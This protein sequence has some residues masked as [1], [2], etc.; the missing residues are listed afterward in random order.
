MG[1]N[2]GEK[3][4]ISLNDWL[5]GMVIFGMVVS[6]MVIFGL[7]KSPWV[8]SREEDAGK[9]RR[10]RQRGGGVAARRLGRGRRR[11]RGGAGPETRDP[12][13]KGARVRDARARNIKETAGAGSRGGR[14]ESRTS[15]APTVGMR[16]EVTPGGLGDR[17]KVESSG[18]LN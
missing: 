13:K 14:V 6:R 18:H 3:G 12:R 15:V 2:R 4:L 11:E 16:P 17:A 7:M 10:Q 9:K 8:K 1:S 5:P